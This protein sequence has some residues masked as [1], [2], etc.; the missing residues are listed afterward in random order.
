MPDDR[1][2]KNREGK[3]R[4]KRGERGEKKGTTSGRKPPRSAW[5]AVHVVRGVA[6]D[7]TD[8]CSTE[9]SAINGQQIKKK[10]KSTLC[11]VLVRVHRMG[12]Q[13]GEKMEVG[14][15]IGLPAP[16][17]ARQ[18]WASSSAHRTARAK[19]LK[20][21]CEMVPKRCRNAVRHSGPPVLPKQLRFVS[22][23]RN[24]WDRP[25]K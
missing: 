19:E 14:Y 15:A 10:V 16:I 21:A 20:K 8:G 23:A 7:C 22:G 2:K 12:L 9:K 17:S 11:H 3:K 5:G 6:R 18:A 24:R 4:E 25:R 13:G 1:E